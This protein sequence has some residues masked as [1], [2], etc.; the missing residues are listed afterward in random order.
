MNY[1]FGNI[2]KLEDF[3]LDNIL[4]DKKSRNDLLIY[5]IS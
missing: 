4:I 2:N 1:Y 5:D 3:D